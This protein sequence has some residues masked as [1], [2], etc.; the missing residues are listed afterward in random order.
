M[1]SR[2]KMR[3]SLFRHWRASGNP[4]KIRASTIGRPLAA[5]RWTSVS[6]IVLFDDHGGV[7]NSLKASNALLVRLR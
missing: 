7:L 6:V 2:S 1:L 3:P 5:E 4:Y